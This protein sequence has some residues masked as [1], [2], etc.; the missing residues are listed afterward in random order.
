MTEVA[1]KFSV[2]I[3]TC[4]RNDLLA[5]CLD[6]VA[7]GVQTMSDDQ[8]EVVV[9]DDG[10]HS[11]T[12]DL[13]ALRYP[14]VR[15]TQGPANGIGANRNH[16]AR[17]A[18]GDYLI[19]IDDDCLPD[20]GWLLAFQHAIEQ[21]GTSIST[22][23][24]ATL[25]MEEFPSLLWEAPH[26]D[27]GGARIS[28]NFAVERKAF[29]DS[30]GFDERFKKSFEDIE[31]FSR[32]AASGKG[33]QFVENAI[34]RHPI[35]RIRS[36]VVLAN[37]WESRVISSLDQGASPPTVMWRLLWHVARVIQS[38]FK[39]KPFALG[40]LWAAVLFLLEWLLVVWKTPGWVLKWS[41]RPRSEFW[42]KYVSRNGSAPRYGF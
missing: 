7:P 27:L 6:L 20:P 10:R 38:R 37:R 24:G 3:P 34:V 14:W 9:T 23:E 35:R 26:N 11:S 22:F 1:P 15:W 5:K 30:G 29:L 16:G 36:A 18:K 21:S 42:S 17:Q 19:F 4:H 2:V 25:R 31:F 12:T 8:Y 13:I 32:W 39:R 28:A 40:N 33:E 41:R